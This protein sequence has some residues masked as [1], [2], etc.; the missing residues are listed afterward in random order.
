[1]NE[2]SIVRAAQRGDLLA[3]D[4]L[5]DTLAP[6]VGQI[7]GTIALD[8]G[9]DAA[10]E[11]LIQILRDIGQLRSPEALRGW[12]RRIATREAIRHARKARRLQPLPDGFEPSSTPVPE[13]AADIERILRELEPEQ[14]AILILRDLDGLSEREAAEQ[15]G[16]ALGTVKSRLHRARTAFTRLWH[17]DEPQRKGTDG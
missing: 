12:A 2:P 7:C 11:A 13:A 8:D 14:R 17:A 3:I 15:L 9:P 16:V 5:L 10:Q 1:M 4:A 6:Y